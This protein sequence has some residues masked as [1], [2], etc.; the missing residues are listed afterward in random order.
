[1]VRLQKHCWSIR[2]RGEK[3]QCLWFEPSLRLRAKWE[4]SRDSTPKPEKKEAVASDGSWLSCLFDWPWWTHLAFL[5]G[6][7]MISF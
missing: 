2:V 6:R 3:F 7:T 4:Q 1:M 5:T